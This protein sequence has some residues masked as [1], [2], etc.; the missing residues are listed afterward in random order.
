MHAA[1]ERRGD[2]QAQDSGP[3]AH[4]EDGDGPHKQT[5]RQHRDGDRQ[6]GDKATYLEAVKSGRSQMRRPAHDSSMSWR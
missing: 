4:R 6:Q 1:R 5:G 2:G 3:G